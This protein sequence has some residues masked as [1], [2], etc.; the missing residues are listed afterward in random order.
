MYLKTTS[1][2]MVRITFPVTFPNISAFG[3]FLRRESRINIE[4]SL[5]ESF[6]FVLQEL[7][8]LIERPRIQFPVKV[9]TFPA[10]DSDACQV[11][12]RKDVIGHVNNGFRYT[13]IG[14]SHKLFLFSAKFFEMPLSRLSAFGLQILSEKSVFASNVFHGFSVKENV[15]RANCN[16]YDTSVNSENFLTGWFGRFCSEN[17]IQE[18]TVFPDIVF[19]SRTPDAPIC[20]ASVTFRDIESCFDSSVDGSKTHSFMFQEIGNHS[21]IIPD[22]RERFSYRKSFELNSFQSFTR[23][24]SSSLNQRGRKF[25]V[26]FSD[27]FVGSVMDRYFAMGFM[28]KPIL[29][30]FVKHSVKNVNG[31]FEDFF[32]FLKNTEFKFDSSIHIHILAS[33]VNKFKEVTK[34]Q[35]VGKLTAFLP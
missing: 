26:F 18:K 32:I 31:F 19:Q 7:C 9:F 5:T 21:L 11:F 8:K 24:I 29:S 12:E 16:V 25:W 3:A 2:A 33:I 6:G 20:V 34:V 28:V 13:V 23:N 17:Y 14:I 27:L 10:L 30:N 1:F 15:V 4:N 22:G 35:D